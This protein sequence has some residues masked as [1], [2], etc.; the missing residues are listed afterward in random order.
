M[1]PFCFWEREKG[2]R[3]REDLEMRKDIV[4]LQERERVHELSERERER[5]RTAARESSSLLS[6]QSVSL[7]KVSPLIT[8]SKGP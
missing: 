4:L 5:E 8:S 6:R 2:R 7:S 1:G 3:T